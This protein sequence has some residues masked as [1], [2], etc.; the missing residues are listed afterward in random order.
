MQLK[1]WECSELAASLVADVDGV[2]QDDEESVWDALEEKYDIT[3]DGF[4]MLVGDLIPYIQVGHSLLTG[5]GYVGFGKN[6][7]DNIVEMFVKI[8]TDEAEAGR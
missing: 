5:T 7:N 1:T 2:K 8:V 6:L 3:P 4:A